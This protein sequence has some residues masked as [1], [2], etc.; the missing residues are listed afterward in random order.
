MLWR[1]AFVGH[2]LA[3]SG[4]LTAPI[5]GDPNAVAIPFMFFGIAFAYSLQLRRAEAAQRAAE[6]R[7]A[8]QQSGSTAPLAGWA[9]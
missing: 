1:L 4:S 3:L 9:A 5:Y 6:D 7:A 2:F 8:P